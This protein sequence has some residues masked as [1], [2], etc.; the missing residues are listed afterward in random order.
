MRTYWDRTTNSTLQ[1]SQ[2]TNV[3]DYKTPQQENGLD[4][5]V[6]VL[7][8]AELYTRTGRWMHELQSAKDDVQVA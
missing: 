1:M 3:L 8:M 2:W 7:K 4:C 6:F 5:G